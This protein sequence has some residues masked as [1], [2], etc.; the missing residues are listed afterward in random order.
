MD[1]YSVGTRG[2]K[3]PTH[4]REIYGLRMWAYNLF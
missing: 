1:I 4:M 3:R 2:Q